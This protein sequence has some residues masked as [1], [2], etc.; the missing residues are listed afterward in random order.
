M[1][2]L[3]EKWPRRVEIYP[4]DEAPATREPELDQ[5]HL[6]TDIGFL[7]TFEAAAFLRDLAAEPD[8][9][10][11]LRNLCAAE[12]TAYRY[13]SNEEVIE[14]FA[15][16]VAQ[17]FYR[18]RQTEFFRTAWPI[19]PPAS[20]PSPQPN[21][22]PKR[23]DPP[24]P[25][26][27]KAVLVEFIEVVNRGVEGVVT[28]AGPA[29]SILPT[30]VERSDIQKGFYKQFI[31]VTDKDLEGTSKRHPEYGR[32]IE[33]KARVTLNG[34][35]KAGES[36]EFSYTRQAGEF[37]PLL[38]TQ[39]KQGFDHPGSPPTLIQTT[40]GDGW[41]K[42]VR[43]YLS[44]YAG[45]YFELFA[46]GPDGKKLKLG[47]Y[48]VWRKFWYQMTHFKNSVPPQL[49][50]AQ[51]TYA[52]VF[53]EMA[54][55]ITQQVDEQTVPHGSF[56]PGWMAQYGGGTEMVSVVGPHNHEA[57]F[58]LCKNEQDKP[59]KG[60]L[61]VC[62]TAW[63]A[64]TAPVT[65]ESFVINSNP[66]E[67]LTLDLQGGR[68]LGIFKPTL[69]G[70]DLVIQ[71]TWSS[72]SAS[73]VLTDENILIE[74]AGRTNLR[75]IKVLLPHQAPN[76]AIFPVTVHLQLRYAH[77]VGGY[78]IGEHMVITSD[79][80]MTAE[81]FNGIVVHEFGHGFNQPPYPDRQPP[82]LKSHPMQYIPQGGAGSHCRTGATPQVPDA[83]KPAEFIYKD[84][85]C[86]MFHAPS[87]KATG[88]FCSTCHPYIRLQN[89][90]KLEDPSE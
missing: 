21:I 36:V 75:Q 73:G 52:A 29:S 37:C 20:P 81:M 12:L 60:H 54:A 46:K 2:I 58:N 63:D 88:M 15:G 51:N 22:P 47:S 76:P 78:S 66:S 61:V 85:S 24:K 34:K 53:A 32:Y 50:F 62:D 72:D 38:L 17:H 71:G 90:E 80:A 82:P 5:S 6:V 19:E 79:N 16:L 42:T 11:Q 41:T 59:I 25:V 44:A 67:L 13:T 7:D 48:Q 55:S 56:Y 23:T 84:G 83:N 18:V 89:M 65:V 68:N 28:G 31:N 87:D 33:V 77:K 64:Y 27:N 70:D 9:M 40:G 69:T 35:P 57:F 3:F 43:F 14:Q 45:D 86:V 8:L 49:D 26:E 30:C 74:P 4:W 1:T 39:D 10:G